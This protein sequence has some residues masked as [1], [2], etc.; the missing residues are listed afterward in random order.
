MTQFERIIF[1]EEHL[2]SDIVAAASTP[3]GYVNAFQGEHTQ[4]DQ[5]KH[6]FLTGSIEEPVLNETAA[7]SDAEQHSLRIQSYG[8][9]ATLTSVIGERIAIG[10]AGPGDPMLH[11]MM[12]SEM[13][14]LAFVHGAERLTT[15]T[16]AYLTEDMKGWAHE[17]WRP[18]DPQLARPL[19]RAHLPFALQACEQMGN[20]ANSAHH[21]ALEQFIAI[22]EGVGEQP[23]PHMPTAAGLAMLKELIMDR[24]GA[25]FEYMFADANPEQTQFSMQEAATIFKRV[26]EHRGLSDKGWQLVHDEDQFTNLSVAA[27]LKQV[28]LGRRT[29][30]SFKR[31]DIMRLAFHEIGVHAE[32]AQNA[33]DAGMSP[34]LR[35]GLPG[36]LAAEEGFCNLAEFALQGKV[37]N[38]L[39]RYRYVR[40]SVAEGAVDGRLR[41]F[42][43]SFP[44]LGGYAIADMV[45]RGVELTDVTIDK[46]VSSAYNQAVR[47]SRGMPPAVPGLQDLSGLSYYDGAYRVWRDLF[48]PESGAPYAEPERFASLFVGKYDR[49]DANHR[50][51]VEAMS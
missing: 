29:G 48:S 27:S 40:G 32:T 38:K 33:E 3:E 8:K 21:L 45:G 13:S 2:A 37:A 4:R 20:V 19:L 14:K 39:H 16:P 28:R 26:L 35:R 11:T 36:Y 7:L 44:I 50:A 24:F 30:S 47:F 46:E 41:T 49:T 12:K 31:M 22:A 25:T 15:D 34:L 42:G 18:A 5:T 9:L 17:I 23:E 1:D 6:D 51:F 10:E 43:E